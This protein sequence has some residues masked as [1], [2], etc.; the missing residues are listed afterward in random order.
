MTASEYKKRGGSYTTSKEEGQSKSQKHLQQWTDEQWQTKEGS[1]TA[2]QEDE[3]RQRY[4][5]KKAWE[6]MS[7]KEKNETEERKITAS[8][9]GKQYVG[10]TPEAKSARKKASQDMVESDDEGKEEKHDASETNQ[11][12]TGATRQPSTGKQFG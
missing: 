3:T 2:R 7:D 10:N 5:P 11:G 1:R 8:Q 6:K 9:E 12:Q 4:L